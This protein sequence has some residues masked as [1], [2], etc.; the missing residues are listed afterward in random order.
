MTLTSRILHHQS[1]LLTNAKGMLTVLADV[2]GSCMVRTVRTRV[3]TGIYVFVEMCGRI[4]LSGEKISACAGTA[5]R[6]R[7]Q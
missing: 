7:Q 3:R 4:C 5:E 2:S 6:A 1:I